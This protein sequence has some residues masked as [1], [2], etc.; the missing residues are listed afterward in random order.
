MKSILNNKRQ[1]H[2][3]DEASPDFWPLGVQSNANGPVLN[4]ARLKALTCLTHVL[5]CPFVVLKKG[6]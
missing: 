4:A 5:D 2:S 3:F 6:R 1:T